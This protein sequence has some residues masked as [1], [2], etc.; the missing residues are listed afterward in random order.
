MH[1]LNTCMY[2][3]ILVGQLRTMGVGWRHYS[4]STVSSFIRKLSQALWYLD[5]H[6]TKFQGQGRSFF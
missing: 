5:P 2:Y 6:H 1:R 4:I 3:I